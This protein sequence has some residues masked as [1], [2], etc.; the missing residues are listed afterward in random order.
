MTAHHSV[1]TGGLTHSAGSLQ[2]DEWVGTTKV[3]VSPSAA[4]RAITTAWA[5]PA[6]QPRERREEWTITVMASPRPS[7]RRSEMSMATVT[8][9]RGC[10]SGEGRSLMDEGIG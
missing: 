5:P 10:S 7:E 8:G 1:G 6:T 9:P 3:P 4:R 2:S